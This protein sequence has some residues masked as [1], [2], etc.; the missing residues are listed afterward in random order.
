MFFDLRR[1]RTELLRKW[2]LKPNI[3]RRRQVAYSGQLAGPSLQFICQNTELD[4][5]KKG[6]CRWAA[7]LSHSPSSIEDSS[8]FLTIFLRSY[9][10]ENSLNRDQ[11]KKKKQQTKLECLGQQPH[12]NSDILGLFFKSFTKC[13]QAL[14]PKGKGKLLPGSIGLLTPPTILCPEA[15]NTAFYQSPAQWSGGH[16]SRWQSHLLP[17]NAQKQLLLFGFSPEQK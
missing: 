9:N 17:G 5:I 12:F 1:E 3:Q 14:N 15:R 7:Q 6:A 2:T 10:Y 11:K 16:I 13:K 4:L 8:G